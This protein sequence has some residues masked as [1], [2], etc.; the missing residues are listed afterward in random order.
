[1]IEDL[2]RRVRQAPRNS[3]IGG[4]CMNIRVHIWGCTVVP[5]TLM[6]TQEYPSAPVPM[7]ALER[8][9][10]MVDF[11]TAPGEPAANIEQMQ[12]ASHEVEGEAQ[13]GGGPFNE[14]TKYM[15]PLRVITVRPIP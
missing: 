5:T 9:I 6:R 15:P 13:Q 1:M 7:T 2:D 4:G 8:E 14:Q 12:P 3:V 10:K 11:H